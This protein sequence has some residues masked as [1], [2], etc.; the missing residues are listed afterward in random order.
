MDRKTL[1][2]NMQKLTNIKEA[3]IPNFDAPLYETPESAGAGS[4]FETPEQKSLKNIAIALR[5]IEA[6]LEQLNKS[7]RK[8]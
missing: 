7:L 1:I 8:K 6:Q 4:S 5:G 3:E 2:N